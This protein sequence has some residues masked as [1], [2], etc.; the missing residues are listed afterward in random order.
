MVV[1]SD[2]QFLAKKCAAPGD[3]IRGRHHW[4]R[5][6]GQLKEEV[7]Y[8]AKCNSQDW[9]VEEGDDSLAAVSI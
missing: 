5:S 2:G 7:C 6:A 8:F 1:S 3:H 9:G 4:R